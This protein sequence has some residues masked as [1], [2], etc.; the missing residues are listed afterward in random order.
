MKIYLN[1]AGAYLY[2]MFDVKYKN[3]IAIGELMRTNVF[4]YSI[5]INTVWCKSEDI[6]KMPIASDHNHIHSYQIQ[7]RNWSTCLYLHG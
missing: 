6:V 1:I 3:T 2:I 4:I 7:Y 5:Y